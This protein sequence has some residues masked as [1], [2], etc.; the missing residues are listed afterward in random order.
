MSTPERALF[1]AAIMARL[2]EYFWFAWLFAGLL[3]VGLAR[4]RQL[5]RLRLCCAV[6]LRLLF[7][8]IALGA[9]ILFALWCTLNDGI[10]CLI[11]P[12]KEGLDE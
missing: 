7:A 5:K 3:T 1:V 8:P 2:A 12:D 9:A 6:A 10:E 11:H 4:V